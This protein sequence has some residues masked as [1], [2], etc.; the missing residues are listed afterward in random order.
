MMP[1]LEAY[2]SLSGYRMYAIYDDDAIDR[3]VRRALP[4]IDDK[5]PNEAKIIMDELKRSLGISSP[6]QWYNLL[7][8]EQISKVPKGITLKR[9]SKFRK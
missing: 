9:P 8:R 4:L 5:Q 1:D 2:F 3:I 7:S 6:E